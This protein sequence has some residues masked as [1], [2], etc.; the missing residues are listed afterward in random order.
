MKYSF[1]IL[2]TIVNLILSITTKAN[3]HPDSLMYELAKCTEI[4]KRVD[5]LLSLSKSY[6]LSD[7]KKANKFALQAIDEAMKQSLSQIKLTTFRN[8]AYLNYINTNYREAMVYL[9]QKLKLADSINDRS[10]KSWVYNMIGNIYYSIGDF[11]KSKEYYEL[12]LPLF[13]ELGYMVGIGYMYTNLGNYYEAKRDF[14]KADE[15]YRMALRVQDDTGLESEKILIYNNLGNLY[16]KHKKDTLALIFFKEALNRI[17]S[18][19][20]VRNR[21]LVYN[22]IGD[23]YFWTKD[24]RNALRYLTKGYDLANENNL[25]TFIKDISKSLVDVY[26]AK[27]D[28]SKAYDYQKKFILYNDSLQKRNNASKI[29]FLDFQYQNEQTEYQQKL[30]REEL[31]RKAYVRSLMLWAV[32]IVAISV[33]STL[34]VLYRGY[35]R[36][37]KLKREKLE[38]ERNYLEKQVDLKNKEIVIK[39]VNLLERNELIKQ[40]VSRLRAVNLEVNRNCQ[41]EL[42]SIVGELRAKYQE[43]IL[44]EFE[45]RF[46]EVHENFYKQIKDK[47]PNLT[48]NDLRLCAFLKM[49]FSSK[50]IAS[51]TH[52][53]L[54]SIQMARKRLRKKLGFGNVEINLDDYI[55]KF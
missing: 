46:G 6:L 52:Q 32:T 17:D 7:Y 42:D 45:V 30:Q 10:A 41:T 23:F 29:S 31:S 25:L 4:E 3:N 44:S 9:L 37:E 16:Y 48:V 18:S 11:D 12:C 1:Y 13:E 35:K 21:V 15:Y 47:H 20:S 5:I 28:F 43:N 38:L 50:D 54:N 22:N 14:Y 53:P 33:L 40:V 19:T 8:A 49:Q 24:Y 27:G 39:T 2:V 26:A 51:L 36:R 34:A 55:S